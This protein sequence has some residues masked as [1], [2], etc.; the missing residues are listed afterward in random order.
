MLHLI[1]NVFKLSVGAQLALA[2]GPGL[3]HGPQQHALVTL[4]VRIQASVNS[5][6]LNPLFAHLH[7]LHVPVELHP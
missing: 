1:R 6:R 3:G 2:Y 4:A 7:A 5:E